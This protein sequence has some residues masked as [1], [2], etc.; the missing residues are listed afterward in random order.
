MSQLYEATLLYGE[1]YILK[2]RVF[3]RDEAQLVDEETMAVLKENAFLKEKSETR[4][5]GVKVV[6]TRQKPQF[7]FK[8]MKEPKEPSK[9]AGKDKDTS[10]TDN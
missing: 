6:E 7:Q 8:L 3:K 2:G 5:G 9:K 10:D 4:Q 1:H